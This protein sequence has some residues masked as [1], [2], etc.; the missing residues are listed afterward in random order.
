[1]EYI[2]TT[3]IDAFNDAAAVRIPTHDLLAVVP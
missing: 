2:L 3:A 1:V